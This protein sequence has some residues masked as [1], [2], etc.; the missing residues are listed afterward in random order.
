MKISAARLQDFYPAGILLYYYKIM[1]KSALAWITTRSTPKKSEVPISTESG[2]HSAATDPSKL[3]TKVDADIVLSFLRNNFAADAASLTPIAEGEISH[4]FSFSSERGGFVIRV[5]SEANHLKFH[6]FEKDLYASEHF[7]RWG[8]PVPRTHELGPLTDGFFYSIT[9]KAAGRTL[10]HFTKPEIRRMMPELIRVLDAIHA[11]EIGD[12]LFG[13]WGMH[14]EST[15]AS[16]QDFLRIRWEDFRAHEE[17]QDGPTLLEPDVVGILRA[18]YGELIDYCG[19]VRQLVHGDYGFNNVLADGRKI[20][21]VIDWQESKYGDFLF[22]VAW[23]SFWDTD[24]DYAEIFRN[25]YHDRNI[26]VP[27]FCERL[28]CYQL[29]IGLGALRAYSNSNH[30]KPY[31]W[32]KKRLLDLI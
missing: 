7:S 13:N 16:W 32:A 4:A 2:G 3:K 17:K 18:R 8:I 11:V 31:E 14:G 9:E 10:D 24:I 15:E 27:N 25:H 1:L 5:L 6:T 26:A 28:L 19:N 23:L 22:D 30:T 21:A 20:T 29:N 12:T